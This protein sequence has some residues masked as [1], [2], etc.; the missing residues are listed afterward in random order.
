MGSLYEQVR[1]FFEEDDWGYVEGPNDNVLRYG[2]SGQNAKFQGIA[3]VDDE[4]RHILFL[5]YLPTHVPEN[6]RTAAAEYV[7]RANYGLLN[8]NFELDFSDGEVRFKVSVLI[9]DS[10]LTFEQF[11]TAVYTCVLTMDRYCA[12]LM[13]VI[14]ADKNPAECIAAI[15]GKQE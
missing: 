9:E 13:E 2:F 1:V 15:E 6:K 4:R 5:C 12:G 8:G 11:K 7:T 14:Y 3:K 10:R